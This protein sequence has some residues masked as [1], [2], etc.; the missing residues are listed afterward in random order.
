[1]SRDLHSEIKTKLKDDIM[2]GALTKFAEQYP[3]A[4]LKSYE[5]VGDGSQEAIDEL[6]D[7][8]RDMK[9][10]TV[11]N[12]EKYADEFQK[13]VEE[14]GGVVYRAKDGDDLK[15]YLIKIANENGVKRIVK[16]KS[17]A[18]EEIHLNHDL[19][20]K[21]FH[22]RETDLGEWMLAVAGQKP[23]H[24]VMPA[25]HL[26]RQQCAK[27]FSQE[28]KE[29]IPSD[30]PFMIQTAR[31]V[32]REE[33][34]TADMGI[35]GANFG[36]AENG[37][38]GL[39]TNE[40]N[41][42]LVTTL[43]RIHVVI[44][45]YEKLIPKVKDIAKIVRLL[46]RNGTCQRMTSYMTMVDGP[47][48]VIYKK[49]GEWVEENRKQYV[50]LLDN[51]RLKAAHDPKM[52]QA[53]QCV[54]CASCLNVCP[55]WTL[56]GGHVYG[57]IYSGGIGAILTGLLGKGSMEA[58]GQF[59]DLCIGCRKCV[60][61][62]PG[63]VPIP[64]LIDELRH[65]N[66]KE[67]GLSF[68]EKMAFQHILTNRSLF[69]TLLRA[70]SLAQK[71]VQSGKF[72][73]HLPLFFAHLTEGRSLPAVSDRPMRDRMAELSK[74]NPANPVKRVA[75]F[76]GCNL[77]FVFPDTAENVV[78]VLQDLGM[79]VVFPEAQSCCGKPAIGMG[80]RDTGKVLA[81]QNIEAF[82]KSGADVIICACPTCA[83][84]LEK[85][86]VEMFAED[87]SWRT[88]V[89]LF[90]AKIREFTSFV[91]EEYEK[92]GRLKETEGN[93]KV[94]YHDSCHMRRGLGVWKEPRA[95]LK[96]AKGVDFVEMHNPDKCCGMAGAFGMRYAEISLPML[97]EKL[98]NVKNTG[99]ST[100]A[101][102]CPACMMQIG[103]GLDQELPNVKVKHVAD[104]LA[105]RL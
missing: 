73:R 39:V 92:Q 33:F 67:K 68:P 86:Y 90:A 99:A 71:P 50:I 32:L 6:R 101:V 80:D 24:M 96:A 56:V 89:E 45:G 100:V 40:G 84:T 52:R 7:D 15:Q 70:A 91:A 18:T 64:D 62:C 48:P 14:R 12:I 9:L 82:E 19:E 59:S 78:K 49:D 79:E 8:L 58:F 16:S 2:Q 25:I 103:G 5:N 94:T 3:G 23:S 21:G 63:K 81:K 77:D 22:V 57:H 35:T 88:R 83:E 17:M 85:T 98:T 30:I 76:S 43:P 13:S 60:S 27:F 102:A 55:I 46:P 26:N 54:R 87:S 97:K 51:G 95:L 10:R 105:E 44:I 37:A 72:I 66:V 28:L 34:R 4:R 61:I 41:A 65:R 11:E 93:E 104:I 20:E 69:H 31:R 36:V 74:K 38:I 1:M 29:E 75:F 47:T 53:F 42:R